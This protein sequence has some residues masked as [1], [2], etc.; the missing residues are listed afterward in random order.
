MEI[1]N[2]ASV[3]QLLLKPIHLLIPRPCATSACRESE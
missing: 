2:A 3:K 1:V